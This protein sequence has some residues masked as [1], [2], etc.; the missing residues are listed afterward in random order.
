MMI[1][2]AVLLGVGAS[3]QA[4]ASVPPYQAQGSVVI[5]WRDV[6]LGAIGLVLTVAGFAWKVWSATLELRL[7][8]IH[9]KMA[10]MDEKGTQ[11]LVNHK[12]E[13]ATFRSNT[14]SSIN[15]L[16]E[17]KQRHENSIVQH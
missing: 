17:F 15:M 13:M 1:S 6:A 7:Q 8:I 4:Q 10:R 11:S 5:Y 9:H 12:L 14:E 16:K 3:L 2:G